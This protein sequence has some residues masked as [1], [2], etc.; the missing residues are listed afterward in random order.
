[1]RRNVEKFTFI[2]PYH[3]IMVFSFFVL[4]GF[5]KLI[6]SLIIHFARKFT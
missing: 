1:M 2:M 6:Y 3:L 5:T 4:D